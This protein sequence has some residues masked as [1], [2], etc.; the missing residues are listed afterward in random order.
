[1]RA[2]ADKT[3]FPIF[4]NN[5]L[6]M[7][8]DPVLTAR[9]AGSRVA[10]FNSPSDEEAGDRA[11]LTPQRFSKE[12]CSGG[13]PRCRGG[14]TVADTMSNVWASTLLTLLTALP[15]WASDSIVDEPDGASYH[16]TSHYSASI[17]A[18]A[19]E[20]WRHLANLGAWMYEFEMAPVEGTA[21]E[22]G[23]VFRLY[24][25]QDFHVQVVKKIPAKLMVIANLPSTFRGE[26]S[27]G[28]GVITLHESGGET[29]V[30]LTMIRR[31]T[32]QG[33]GDNPLRSERASI[34]FSENTR[35]MWE[36]RFLGRLR[37]LA[38]AG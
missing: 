11:M 24:E 26:F 20:V 25:G 30:D 21:G 13:R 9:V 14:G 34:G 31:Y 1:M 22:E 17:A 38:E 10:D 29:T 5:H 15:A 2:S 4:F 18:P 23:E 12:S 19:D 8:G 35:A 7:T 27:T 37:S 36:D 28:T 32:W 3:E 16:Y 33:E 6:P